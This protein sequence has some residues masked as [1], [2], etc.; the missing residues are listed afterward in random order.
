VPVPAELR[1]LACEL[2]FVIPP[3]P[4]ANRETT[5][6]YVLHLPDNRTV[7]FTSAGRLRLQDGDVEAIR[8]R[9]REAGRDFLTWWVSPDAEPDALADRLA[10]GGAV[11][12]ESPLVEAEL[13]AMVLTDEP[14]PPPGNVVARVVADE[15]EYLLASE[16]FWAGHE[17]PEADRE[18]LRAE[19][20]ELYRRRQLS[21]ERRTYLAWIDGEP[22]A[23]ASASFG[24]G[25]AALSGAVT[26]PHARGGGAYSA[27]VHARW[28]D[29]RDRGLCG[30]AVQAQ[31]MSAP[32]LAR[33]GFESL[34]RVR[35]LYDRLT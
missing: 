35:L 13:E 26:L 4:R 28:R 5:D 10:A 23:T 22:V 19:A 33:R 6:R 12:L 21:G 11:P 17:V 18:R 32:I 29:T 30:L 31:A 3:P 2:W 1:L 7:P 14:S 8:G 16:V 24:S 27:L 9:F 20:P 34:G 15:A 25:G